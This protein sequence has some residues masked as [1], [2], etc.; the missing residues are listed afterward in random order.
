MIDAMLLEGYLTDPKVTV[1]IVEHAAYAKLRTFSITGS[2]IKPGIY[3]LEGTVKLMDAIGSAD[4]LAPDADT[5]KITINRTDT[6]GEKTMFLLD[7]EKDGKTFGIRGRDRIE[8]PSFGTYFIYGEVMRPG[9]YFITTDLMVADAI[10]A[11]G[12]F[13][14]MAYEGR[15]RVIRKTDEEPEAGAGT[16]T[17]EGEGAEQVSETEPP[18][19]AEGYDNTSSGRNNGSNFAKD[20]K[21]NTKEKDVVRKKNIQRKRRQDDKEVIKVPVAHIFET[22][23]KSKDILVLDKD[24]IVVN[25]AWF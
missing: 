17:L 13:S 24:I 23:D 11:A 15:V 25:E 16:G 22:G 4:G 3:L 20:S 14:D 2:V 18:S 8:I 6:T 21:E 19:A 5:S 7:L 1:F 10:I 12:G 9:K